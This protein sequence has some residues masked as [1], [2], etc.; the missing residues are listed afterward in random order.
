MW[1][2]WQRRSEDTVKSS[3]SFLAFGLAHGDSDRTVDDRQMEA[4]RE[5]SSQGVVVASRPAGG[6]QLQL[7]FDPPTDPHADPHDLGSGWLGQFAASAGDVLDLS[8]MV[9]RDLFGILRDVSVDR[10]A[11]HRSRKSGVEQHVTPR[12]P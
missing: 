6:H 8:G 11:I 10:E 9:S 1:V 5:Q 7:L 12:C 4:A 3:F 2:H